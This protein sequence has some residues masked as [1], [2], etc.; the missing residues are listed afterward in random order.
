M[1]F[2]ACKATGE[3]P[4]RCVYLHGL[5]RDSQGRKMSKLLGNGIDPLDIIDKYGADA[6]R[7]MLS[8]GIT[9]GNDM[10]FTS[11]RL[12]SSRNFANKLWNASRFVIINIQD[13]NGDF[14][15]MG[16]GINGALRDEDKWI[17]SRLAD[18]NAYI[19]KA[20][21]RFDIAMVGQR[22]YDMIWN[23][24]CDWYIEF[25][26]KRLWN[27][28][29]HNNDKRQRRSGFSGNSSS[30]ASSKINVLRFKYT[31]ENGG[32][33]PARQFNPCGAGK[34]PIPVGRRNVRAARSG[35]RQIL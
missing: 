2:A 18:A 27:G 32:N 14:L 20:M 7:F 1:V 29:R 23:E 33:R 30:N 8:T 16:D 24:F 34:P 22:I 3:P 25:V 11:D 10:R 9:P 35:D 12:E 21:D 19:D 28:E 31:A 15:P 26:K 17:I 13:E 5:V 4:F 6:L